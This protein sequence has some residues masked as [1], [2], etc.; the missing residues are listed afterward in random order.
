M[1][2]FPSLKKSKF[3]PKKPSY[4]KIR[5]SNVQSSGS[6]ESMESKDDVH[7]LGYENSTIIKYD[8][9]PIPQE[10]KDPDLMELKDQ[11]TID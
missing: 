10:E 8:L 7:E 9:T 11:K 2:V 3:K 1:N 6:V 5:K 4:F